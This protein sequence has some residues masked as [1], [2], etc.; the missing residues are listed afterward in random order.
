MQM[1]SQSVEEV[2]DQD[3]IVV[4]AIDKL[5]SQMTLRQQTNV[6]KLVTLIEQDMEANRAEM[7]SKIPQFIKDYQK[8]NSALL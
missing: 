5:N 6:K 1:A 4:S 3:R 8:K 7:S 2:Q